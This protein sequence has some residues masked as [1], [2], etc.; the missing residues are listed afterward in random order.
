MQYL[1]NDVFDEEVEL[2]LKCTHYI[3]VVGIKLKDHPLVPL[4]YKSIDEKIG[5]YVKKI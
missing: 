5:N 4:C 1:V 3:L 2:W